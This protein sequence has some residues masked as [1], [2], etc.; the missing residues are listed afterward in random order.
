MA[1]SRG[2]LWEG[3]GLGDWGRGGWPR[4]CS[5]PFTV[6]VSEAALTRTSAIRLPPCLGP[7]T[8]RGGGVGGGKGRGWGAVGEESPPGRR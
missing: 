6:S 8:R 2:A 7:E 5:C 1:S 4:H 3:Q